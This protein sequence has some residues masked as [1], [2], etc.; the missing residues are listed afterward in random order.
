M[1]GYHLM[2]LKYY[3]DHEDEMLI[4]HRMQRAA[5]WREKNYCSN[6]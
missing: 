5:N 6:G 3:Y 1:A 4:S 2:I